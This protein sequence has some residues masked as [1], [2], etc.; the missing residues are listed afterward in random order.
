M[1]SSFTDAAG[2]PTWNALLEQTTLF[3]ALTYNDTFRRDQILAICGG[4][5][6]L[7]WDWSTG[8]W[9]P[10]LLMIRQGNVLYIHVTGTENINQWYGDVIGA[11]A[12]PYQS[13]GCKVHVFF[14]QAWASVKARIVANLP[15]DWQTCE[16]RFF[17]H[18]LGAAVAFLG[19][20]DWQRSNPLMRVELLSLAMPKSLTVG[21]TDRLP[22]T[23]NFIASQADVVPLLPMN[24]IV[25]ASIFLAPQWFLGIPWDWVHYATGWYL[26]NPSLPLLPGST[27]D[28]NVTPNPFL[29]GTTVIHHF[30]SRY[31]AEI[32]GAW[33]NSVGGGR[34]L[35]LVPLAQFLSTSP[36]TQ[37]LVNNIDASQYVD[38]PAQNLLSFNSAGPGPLTEDNLRSVE[39]VSG[40][41]IG[42]TGD[43]PIFTGL[44][45][46]DM[47][48]KVTIFFQDGLGSFTESYY[49]SGLDPGLVTPAMLIAL[50]DARILLAG[51]QTL[52]TKIRVSTVGDARK[53]LL[54]YPQTLSQAVG[55]NHTFQG[56]A[57]API[58]GTVGPAES[59]FSGTALLCRKL[60]G[61]KFSR[62]FMRGIPDRIVVN[63]GQL[64]V[65][66][67]PNFGQNFVN[68][69][70]VLA[71]GWSWR[72]VAGVQP[73]PQGLVSAVTGTD[74]LCL[75][76]VAGN[77]FPVVPPNSKLVVRI[78]G[79]RSPGNLNGNFT[80][81]V[82][83]ATQARTVR[84]L[85]VNN[86]VQA[87]GMVRFT[88]VDYLPITRVVMER[89]VSK[90]PGRPSDLF[91]GRAKNVA[92]G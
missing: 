79:Q 38:I 73:T 68:F 31:L 48:S 22:R 6:V 12:T 2:V 58:A 80:V 88:A 42:V 21:Y 30:G 33:Q 37:T 51:A 40:A 77:L 23:C 49:R 47:A 66:Q 46:N 71:N 72:G 86:F 44:S 75:I 90:R 74:G 41:V 59:D 69:S 35:A 45:G 9:P 19:S 78:S 87:N 85:S 5:T 13:F 24:G 81:S 62:M 8:T 91:H 89:I 83:S 53:V 27:D 15:S 29:I 65:T 92:R 18:S 16:F 55:G 56:F 36:E 52:I 63:G 11:Y 25:L 64:D 84:P 50:T 82:V 10:S 17:G 26:Q 67:S 39:S 7:I 28:F 57:N 1:F 54:W 34:N 32:L 4:G 70:L 76:T 20:L 43:H 3:Q 61:L 14:Q 60:S